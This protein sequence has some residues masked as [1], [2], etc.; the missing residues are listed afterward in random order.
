MANSD[1]SRLIN[2][3]EVQSKVNAPKE[4]TKP[5]VLKCNPMK[6]TS[7]MEALNPFA[8][9]AKKKNAAA[10]KA[11]EAAKAKSKK[12]TIKKKVSKSVKEGKT[13]YYE[14][15]IAKS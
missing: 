9:E 8:I 6:S 7:A 13:K 11:N 15:M 12:K 3:D 2:S 14:S 4:G 5:A 10:Q 1:L